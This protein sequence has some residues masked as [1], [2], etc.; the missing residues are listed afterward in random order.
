MLVKVMLVFLAAMVGIA[1]LGNV[2]F[3]GALGRQVKRRLTRRKPASCSRCG[4]P[5]IGQSCD[6]GKR[7]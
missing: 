6:C 3:P 7:G 5:M 4:R 2:L 1:L